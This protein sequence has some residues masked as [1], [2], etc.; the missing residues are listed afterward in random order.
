MMYGSSDQNLEKMKKTPGDIITLHK[1]TKN[2]DQV[3]TWQC[4][5]NFHK[6]TLGISKK[7]FF[8]FNYI[9]ESSVN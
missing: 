8:L 3:I 1:C 9:V 5:K 4:K 7:L 6:S 2:Y